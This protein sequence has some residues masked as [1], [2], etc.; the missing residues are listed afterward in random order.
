[1]MRHLFVLLG[2]F[3][4]AAGS[5]QI[6][7][8]NEW[9]DHSRQH[10]S[11]QVHTDG[12]VRL[13]HALLE[14]AGFPVGSVDP[15]HI[16]V[17]S[18][19]KQV[20]IY[21]QGEEDGVFDPE[22]FIE[23]RG[24][25]NDA[26][27][28]AKLFSN[29]A[30]L[31]DPYFS[32]FND[33]I[34]YY[35]TW[36]ATAPKER[37]KQHTNTDFDAFPLRNWFLADGVNSLV[38]RYFVGP[39]GYY[40][41]TSGF[42]LE[43]EG[44]HWNQFMDAPHQGASERVVPVTLPRI[45]AGADAPE[46]TVHTV[47]AGQNNPGGAQN[48]HHLRIAYGPTAPGVQMIDTLYSGFKVV[49]HS[50]PVPASQLAASFSV[51]FTALADQPISTANDSYNDVQVPSLVRVRYARDFNMGNQS[52]VRM[53]L[54][55]DP[56]GD[57]A[58]LAFN[59][60]S[61]TPV[62]YAYGD[63]VRRIVPVNVSG[64]WKALVPAHASENATVAY[65]MNMGTSVPITSLKLVNN[66][67]YFT[68]LSA[69]GQDS[70]LMIIT[71]R[72][73][74]SSAENYANYRR[75]LSPRNT[76]NV[77]VVDVDELYDQF[78][79]GIPKHPL[80]I[81]RYAKF[82]S[83]HWPSRP[84]SMFLIGKSVQAHRFTNATPSYRPDL[85]GAYA[86]CLVPSYGQPSSDPCFTIGINFNPTEYA[87]PVGR[88]SARTPS[89][90]DDYLAKLIA[91]ESHDP[92]PWM[93]NI[94]HFRGGT[95]AQQTL[96]FGV[97]MSG[98]KAAAED[99]SFGGRVIDFKKNSSGVFQAASADSVK[100][101]IEDE[102]VSLMNFMA[103][104]YADGFEI[105]IDDPSNYQWHGRHPMV[106]GNSCYIGNVHL[107]T[108]NSTPE[109]WVML[110]GKGPIAF[111][112][113]TEVGFAHN[114]AQY[115]TGWYESFS[116]YNYGQGIGEH[117]KHAAANMLGTSDLMSLNTVHT[118][119][120]QG[121]PSLVLNSFPLPDYSIDQAD[122][123]FA[124]ETITADADTFQVKAVVRNVGKAVNASF[125]VE[126]DR[127]A[128]LLG[129]T[130]NYVTTL[131]NVYLND[132]AYFNVPTQTFAGGSGWNTV[133]VK[134]DMEPDEI[135]ELQDTNN[136]IA[137]NTTF[138]T[139]GDLVPVYPYDF[140]IVPD[141]SPMLKASTG[142]PLAPLRTY[143]FQIDTTDLFNSPVLETTT[144]Q[145]PGGVVSWQPQSIYSLN[146]FQDSTVF[147][148]RCSIDSTG[149][150]GYN[151]YERS[152]QYIT[153][154]HG[155]GQAH[156]FQFKKNKYSGIVYDRPDRE[157]EF[158]SG[159]KNLWAQV[160]GNATGE[161]SY[162][163]KW[164]VDLEPQEYSNGCPGQWQVPVFT[165]AVVDPNT[166]EAWRTYHVTEPN[167]PQF[168]NVNNN[169]ACRNRPEKY[170]LFPMNNAA[171]MNGMIGM[172]DAIPDGH[173]IVVY[174]SR[175]LQKDS[176]LHHAPA[177]AT[178]LEQLSGGTLDLAALPDSVPWAMYVRKGDP[179]SYE[180]V[181]GS[182]LTENI[183]LSVWVDVAA[184]Q[185][186]IT[187]PE[188]GPASAWH[189]IYWNDIPEQPTDSTRIILEAIPANGGPPLEFNWSAEI[190]SMDLNISA[191]QYPVLRIK[192]HFFDEYDPQPYPSQIQ[193]WQLLGTPAPECAIHPPLG[194]LNAAQGLYQ[195]QDATV[196]VAVQNLSQFDM[197][198]LLMTAWVVDQNNIKQRIHYKVR[199]PL[200]AGA[201][202][203]DT[204]HF[205]TMGL[206]GAN[207]LIIEANP[208]DTLTG[209]YHQLEQYHFNNIVHVRFD[210]EVDI[211]NP[212]L[213][214]TFD[215]VHIL[216]GDIV[217]ARPEIMITLNDENTVLLMDSPADTAN[218]R[219]YLTQPGGSMERLYFTN[220]H[221]VENMQFIPASGPDNEAKI[222]YRPIFTVDGVYQLAVEGTD[223]SSNHSG[224]NRYRINFEVITRP[225][226]T[227]ILNYPNP[228]TTNTRFVF[229]VTGHQAP[230]YMKIQILTVT[231][232]VVREISSHELGHIRVGRNM[233]DFAWDGTDQ[234]GDRL[235]RGVYLYRV[236]AKLNGE[237]I[238]YRATSASQ[239]FNK[240]FGKMYLLK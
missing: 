192:G 44:Y 234:F 162:G 153:G 182:F 88:L 186:V 224:D 137:S 158:Y 14:D 176:I 198:S 35:L 144:L 108:A 175:Y 30:H 164:G 34:R 138:I 191:Q 18:R 48:D 213:D 193:R 127:S 41:A 163:T 65:V 61:G 4:A 212:L 205:S 238:E 160:R 157:F 146:S 22:D 125:K 79:G 20:P 70:A 91:F 90:V 203:V 156:Y 167:N 136:N 240:G 202:L 106:I 118:F 56:N 220:G 93:K 16:M 132:T 67:G 100:Y 218:F 62:I 183:S 195:G 194:F 217:S 17:F 75:F 38:T 31:A 152:F 103:H 119:T 27:L 6:I 54:P 95:S 15:R 13:G 181:V 3:T 37:V 116:Q 179:G 86:N 46:A 169:G 226:I 149:N 87:I 128:P 142:D 204:I 141:P 134:V 7:H 113:S 196:A 171:S 59:G 117:M 233:T 10:W 25:R 50:F 112:A 83:D 109:N 107:N 99:T 52:F 200:P 57:P 114:L 214:V 72:S 23:F 105:T 227:E 104:A 211:T 210:V 172:F 173:H 230:T 66:T 225:T 98:M 42:Y 221:G 12:V 229:T 187:T 216:D 199:Q 64:M 5:A 222:L 131:T 120:L 94:L 28:D 73:L 124:P 74:L 47:V 209:Q 33:T 89:D 55:D 223:Q 19:E 208:I 49:R 177:V 168:G 111:L 143:L 154:K 78:G 140:A 1:M 129:S 201:F 235:A 77:V 237:D 92:A 24:E 53:I 232:R 68:D 189:K 43:G 2:I 126:L 178:A 155:W 207:T 51:R 9:I 145:A 135:P 58:N 26:W 166:F 180:Q 69:I 122:I 188:A 84:R 123:L 121:D 239:Y 82:A 36:D 231:G 130:Q 45:Y 101:F 150:G 21:I 76:M 190:D 80:S 60:F 110:P 219:V 85:G 63:T 236:I 228:F 8:G 174:T 139:S 32:F 151:W 102:G 206:G 185:G 97:L 29:P 184:N 115:S 161:Q 159:L 170:F 40:G 215:G 96:Q 147:F 81:R 39:N 133:T 165:V 148:W 197:D 71:H 11:F